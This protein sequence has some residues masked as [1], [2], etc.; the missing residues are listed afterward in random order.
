MSYQETRNFL[1]LIMSRPQKDQYLTE[2]NRVFVHRDI[3]G[4]L[5]KLSSDAL[6]AGFDLGIASGHRTIER[7][8]SIWNAKARGDRPVLDDFGCVINTQ[9]LTRKEL[10]WAILRWSAIPGTSRHHW[11]TDIDVFDASALKNGE[12]LQLTQQECEGPFANFHNWLTSYLSVDDAVFFRPYVL[13]AGG[14]AP[15][16]WHLSCAP[17][18]VAYQAAMT[19][20]DLLE[21]I[22]SL[23]IELKNVIKD[24]FDDIYARFIWVPWQLYPKKWLKNEISDI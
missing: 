23:D 11:G 4:H 20:M 5:E 21:L 22:D 8:C 9:N 24:N 14:V 13:P 18:S 15:E 12:K 10:L 7:Q 3:V 2:F 19:K 16:P 1:N 17:L 6:A